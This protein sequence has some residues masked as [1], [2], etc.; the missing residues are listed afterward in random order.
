M[1]TYAN[2]RMGIHW[3]VLA[4]IF[5][6]PLG[7]LLLGIRYFQN[8]KEVVRGGRAMF[9]F[10]V[11]F[12]GLFLLFF[13]VSDPTWEDFWMSLYLFGG[14]ATVGFIMSMF[15]L[16]RGRR[17]EKYKSAV[18]A[19]HMTVIQDI[20]DAVALPVKV[21]ERDLRALIHGG[22]FPGMGIDVIQGKIFVLVTEAKVTRTLRCSGCGA[23][24]T[25]VDK[26]G[27]VCEYCGSP[28]N[29]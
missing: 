26:Q 3:I 1:D 8:R 4:F 11:V 17:D 7:A 13:L 22:V 9:K 20:A 24:V 15:L 25:A 18:E 28:V 12:V 29:Y 19:Q 14:T 6:Q 23:T 21:A 2:K 27:S 16:W 5:I 10:S